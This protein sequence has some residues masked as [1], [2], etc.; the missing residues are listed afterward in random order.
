[1]PTTKL[2][3]VI[4]AYNEQENIPLL[5]QRLR[6]TMEKMRGIESEFIFV[7]DHSADAT[8]TL[9]FEEHSRDPRVKLIRLSR[10][11]GSHVALQAGLACC[12][13]DIAVTLSADLQDPPEIIPL[14]L[15]KIWLGKNIVWAVRETR[16]DGWWYRIRANLY[17]SLFKRFVLP[18]YPRKGADHFM[19]DRKILKA[20]IENPEKNTSLMALICWMGYEQD[21]VCFHRAKRHGGKSKWT[22]AKTFKLVIDSLISFSYLPIRVISFIGF[23][24]S[25]LG[26]IYIVTL[27]YRYFFLKIH[28]VEGWVSLMVVVVFLA[29]V[30]MMMLG[31]LGEYLWR[32]F[33]ETR[34][35]PSYLIE[36][37]V[38]W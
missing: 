32:V 23:L 8:P 12:S 2:S 4:P 9:I 20:L 37:K 26:F 15:D 35:R 29:G 18:G 5:L 19:I 21:E 16:K 14:M 33:E 22:F 3:V 24:I 10:N 13:G 25:I 34:R 1:M 6:S 31:I 7:D 11:S 28:G 30:Q 17:Y 38:G 36:K 27:L